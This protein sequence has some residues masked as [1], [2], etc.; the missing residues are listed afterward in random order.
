M[1]Q[2]WA[3]CGPPDASRSCP[4]PLVLSFSQAVHASEVRVVLGPCGQGGGLLR[5]TLLDASSTGGQEGGGEVTVW[6]NA[7]LPGACPA[8]ALGSPPH[9]ASIM[10]RRRAM[11]VPVP[12][13][14][15]AHAS[16]MHIS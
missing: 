14:H 7:S 8:G 4:A 6:V 15:A 16:H 12:A 2:V 11:H 13:L 10:T 5:V 3:P 1:L 9:Q